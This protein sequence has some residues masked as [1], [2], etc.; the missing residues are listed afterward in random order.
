MRRVLFCIV[1][2]VVSFLF[3]FFSLEQSCFEGYFIW[4]EIRVLKI[5]LQ[6]WGQSLKHVLKDLLKQILKTF[7]PPNVFLLASVPP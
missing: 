1:F 5:E 6:I 4:D 2:V 7:P 3:F